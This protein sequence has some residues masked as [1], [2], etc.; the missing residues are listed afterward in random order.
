MRSW[1]TLVTLRIL[2]FKKTDSFE[3]VAQVYVGGDPS[4]FLG[5][6]F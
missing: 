1:K 5:L 2:F 6:C 3:D 4:Q